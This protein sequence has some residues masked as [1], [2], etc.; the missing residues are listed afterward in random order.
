MKALKLFSTNKGFAILILS[1][2]ILGLFSGIAVNCIQSTGIMSTW[3]LIESPQK[4]SEIISADTSAVW[5]KS[6]DGIIYKWDVFHCFDSNECAWTKN[7][8]IPLRRDNSLASFLKR[9]K[10]CEFDEY[11]APRDA[12]SNMI[13]CV[14]AASIDEDWSQAVY[15]ALL[16]DGKIWYWIHSRGDLNLNNYILRF[17]LISVV[18]TLSMGL[19]VRHQKSKRNNL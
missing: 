4:F 5:A 13:Q 9:N 19:F 7:E 18:S 15:Y 2:A 3:E 10:T 16:D 11:I 12:P 17:T 14:L 6:T 1:G 8:K